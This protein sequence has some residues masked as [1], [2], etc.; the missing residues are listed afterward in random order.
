MAAACHRARRLRRIRSWCSSPQTPS[1]GRLGASS[2]LR[3]ALNPRTARRGSASDPPWCSQVSPMRRASTT[4]THRGV[5]DPRQ[6][7]LTAI[8]LEETLDV[9]EFIEGE[10]EL[11]HCLRDQLLRLGEVVRVIEFFV[12]DPLE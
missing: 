2:E 3:H 10:V 1:R 4:S 8:H 9:S 7:C 5:R 6:S 12:T 11:L